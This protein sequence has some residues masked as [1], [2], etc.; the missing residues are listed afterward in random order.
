[1]IPTSKMTDTQHYI[2]KHHQ[3]QRP[4]R[5]RTPSP[6][7]LPGPHPHHTPQT[8]LRTHAGQ[9]RA[10]EASIPKP[11]NPDP[12][13]QHLHKA[14]HAPT[15]ISPRHD[16]SAPIRACRGAG[17]DSAATHNTTAD[18]LQ[19]FNN[20][21]RPFGPSRLAGV[22]RRRRRRGG[23]GGGEGWLLGPG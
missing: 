1:M 4:V 10:A 21:S 12:I 15:S 3:H 19:K 6:H 16:A 8:P 18:G 9:H 20:R 13:L 23:G 2:W 5:S 22:L 17:S 11:I 7:D 14:A